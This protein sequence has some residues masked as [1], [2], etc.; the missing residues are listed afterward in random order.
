VKT[1]DVKVF[2]VKVFAVNVPFEA[3]IRWAWGVRTG[4]TRTVVQMSTDEEIVGLGEI[5]GGEDRRRL[6]E[7]LGHLVIGEDPFNL[8]RILSKF[9]MTPYHSGYVGVASLSHHMNMRR[10]F[11]GRADG[12]ATEHIAHAI[13]THVIARST[14][15]IDFHSLPKPAIPYTIVE[16]GEPETREKSLNMARAFGVTIR[17][18]PPQQHAMRMQTAATFV[19]R[20]EF[21]V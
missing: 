10:S 16:Y 19:R 3:P 2:A 6:V 20:R 4:T 9:G 17:L 15:F 13:F 14:H 11:P 8:E 18:T 5:T 12:R 7:K 21:P 1:T